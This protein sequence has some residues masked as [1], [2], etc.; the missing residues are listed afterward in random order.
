MIAVEAT[1]NLRGNDS[2]IL[3]NAGIAGLDPIREPTFVVQR[4]YKRAGLGAATRSAFLQ[5]TAKPCQKIRL[6][7]RAEAMV[8]GVNMRLM[9]HLELA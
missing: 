1:G 9:R 7:G 2:G 5:S 6:H 8:D 4:G 3:T